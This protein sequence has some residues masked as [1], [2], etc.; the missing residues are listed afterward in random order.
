MG[1]HERWH[2]LLYAYNGKFHPHLEIEDADGIAEAEYKDVWFPPLTGANTSNIWA[3]ELHFI[4]G[5]WYIYYA[6]DDGQNENHRM[7][8]LESV[9]DDPLGA[10][11]DKGMMEHRWPL[12][13]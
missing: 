11:V 7:F 8:A 1:Y 6:A 5:K 13:D 9:T 10:Y 4:A 2:L 3:P 12:G